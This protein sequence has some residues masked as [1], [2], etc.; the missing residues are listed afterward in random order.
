[1]SITTKTQEN[2]NIQKHF[3]HI[4]HF[5]GIITPLSVE[6]HNKSTKHQ[7]I[8]HQLTVPSGWGRSREGIVDFSTN[9]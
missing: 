5:H 4:R 1:M 8:A 2:S 9:C 6:K 3:R 7:S